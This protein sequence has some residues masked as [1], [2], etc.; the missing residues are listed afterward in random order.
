MAFIKNNFSE[1]GQELSGA[2]SHIKLETAKRDENHIYS[3][4]ETPDPEFMPR[5]IFFL[6]INNTQ[7]TKPT[8]GGQIQPF[9]EAKIHWKYSVRKDM[10]DPVIEGAHFSGTNV[11]Q[12]FSENIY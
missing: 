10:E 2:P 6:Q 9:K 12:W 5:T 8:K 11:Y 1:I 7:N 4:G 3:T